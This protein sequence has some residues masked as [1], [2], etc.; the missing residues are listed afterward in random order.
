[1]GFFDF[2]NNVVACAQGVDVDSVIEQQRKWSIEARLKNATD[3][4]EYVTADSKIISD[5]VLYDGDVGYLEKADFKIAGKG[6]IIFA[7]KS[8]AV[9]SKV[10]FRSVDSCGSRPLVVVRAPGITFSNCIFDGKNSRNAL[11]AD[12]P[13]T[14]D[15]SIIRNCGDK[16][17][18]QDVVTV[19]RKADGRRRSD[20]SI[21]NLKILRCKTEKHL[22]NV[23]DDLRGSCFVDKCIVGQGLFFA[24]GKVNIAE[25]SAE[26]GV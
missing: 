19:V 9:V 13:V 18:S 1:M 6:R 5:L 17:N 21:S 16:S 22:F 25:I 8:S 4:Y 24:G 7:L 15:E 3:C 23:A 26:K 2:L 14:L 12:C 11:E 10:K 20:V